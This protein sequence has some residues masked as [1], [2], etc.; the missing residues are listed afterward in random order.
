[1]C[2]Q[3]LCG[4]FREWKVVLVSSYCL[5]GVRCVRD[6]GTEMHFVYITAAGSSSSVVSFKKKIYYVEY[7]CL[8]NYRIWSLLSLRSW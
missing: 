5:A 8:L 4:F 6:S 1:M 3:L 7:L 2:P